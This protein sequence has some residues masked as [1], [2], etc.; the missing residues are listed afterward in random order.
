[1]NCAIPL[2]TDQSLQ[3]DR[4]LDTDPPWTRMRQV[5]R[6]LGL[7]RRWPASRR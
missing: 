1:M 6:L 3:A 7:V 2:P 5:Y 4:L